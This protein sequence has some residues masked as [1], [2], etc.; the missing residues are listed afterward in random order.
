MICIKF[1]DRQTQCRALG[2]LVGRFSGKVFRSGEIFVPV[3]ALPVQAAADFRFTV[4]GR[5][6]RDLE[7]ELSGRNRP[8]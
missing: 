5:V 3:E 6:T 8:R 7:R 4:L 1:P 2:F